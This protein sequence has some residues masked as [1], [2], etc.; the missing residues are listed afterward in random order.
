VP[1]STVVSS[2]RCQQIWQKIIIFSAAVAA[3][4]PMRKSQSHFQVRFG[5]RRSGFHGE[6][7]YTLMPALK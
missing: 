6:W 3:G 5:E 2:H 7:N 4:V 1:G